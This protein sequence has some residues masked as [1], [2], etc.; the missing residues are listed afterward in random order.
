MERGNRKIIYNFS[1]VWLLCVAGIFA[2]SD[3]LKYLHNNSYCRVHSLANISY[4]SF[5]S[6]FCSILLSHF[7]GFYFVI[8]LDT[9]RN[10]EFKSA[11]R[12]NV[13]KF[14]C[15]WND[16]KKRSI[17]VWPICFC[18]AWKREYTHIACDF[19]FRHFFNSS[20]PSGQICLVYSLIFITFFILF[21]CSFFLHTFT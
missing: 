10:S 4:F 1:K 7:S 8:S 9:N 18:A 14:Q 3:K 16:L 15:V 2:F 19:I 5:H 11:K 17:L 20:D 6:H 13:W 12:K 21:F